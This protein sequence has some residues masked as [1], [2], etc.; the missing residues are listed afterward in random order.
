MP[1]VEF[2]EAQ[3]IFTR[4]MSAANEAHTS[5]KMTHLFE[6]GAGLP[7]QPYLDLLSS[8]LTE[9]VR[10]VRIGFGSISQIREAFLAEKACCNTEATIEWRY[11]P[12]SLRYQRMIMIDEKVVLFGD[13]AVGQF[14][15]SDESTIVLGFKTFFE[16][17]LREAADILLTK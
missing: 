11:H 2:I 6:Q 9:G 14:A 13:S 8:K 4:V 7:Q 16:Q 5:I 17:L 3:A 1:A 10:I 12:N 15:R